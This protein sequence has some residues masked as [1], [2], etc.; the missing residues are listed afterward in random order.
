M[1]KLWERFLSEFKGAVILDK[2][3]SYIYIRKLLWYTNDK[4][5]EEDKGKLNQLIIDSLTNKDGEDI[6]R[7]IADSYRDQYYGEGAVNGFEKGAISGFE[8]GIKQTAI[9]MLKLY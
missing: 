3:N 7:T 4:V 1:L 9:N 2:E 5:A 8:K 6:M